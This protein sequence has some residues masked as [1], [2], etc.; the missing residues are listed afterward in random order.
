[1]IKGV[2]VMPY[3]ET[4]VIFC[5]KRHGISGGIR[6]LSEVIDQNMP[7]SVP[8]YKMHMISEINKPKIDEFHPFSYEFAINALIQSLK[9]EQWESIDLEN[10]SGLNIGHFGVCMK[11]LLNH[12]DFPYDERFQKK[13]GM[14]GFLELPMV[15]E[16][17]EVS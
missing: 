14:N 8:Y 15:N 5:N 3:S 7:W 12:K 13:H 6:S 10:N 4:R 2:S 16:D 11:Q 1:M 9:P 17:I